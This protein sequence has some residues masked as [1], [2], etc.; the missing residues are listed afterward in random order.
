[1]KRSETDPQKHYHAIVNHRFAL[2]KRSWNLFFVLQI[3]V[4]AVS[5]V[6][7]LPI[8]SDRIKALV[9]VGVV[10][11]QILAWVVAN[12]TSKQKAEAEL[13]TRIL[14][15]WFGLGYSPEESYPS[16]KPVAFD[17]K[18]A[19]VPYVFESKYSEGALAFLGV[20]SSNAFFLEELYAKCADFF[21][22]LLIAAGVLIVGSFVAVF[23]FS[24]NWFANVEELNSIHALFARAV[25][26]LIGFVLATNT[27]GM[28]RNWRGSAE[29]LRVLREKI[30]IFVKRD[31]TLV[32]NFIDGEILNF[33][34]DFYQAQALAPLIPWRIHQKERE[35]LLLD[36]SKTP[37]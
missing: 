24:P 6:L 4:A 36:W 13:A 18:L 32:G 31:E 1:M 22:R 2:A 35:K 30:G 37:H 25:I 23:L 28:I 15:I 17:G 34:I 33:I 20:L 29:K 16:L 8:F 14:H 7:L 5:G 21:Y 3:T 26:L 10:G 12:R 11:L 19:V 9:A 27:V